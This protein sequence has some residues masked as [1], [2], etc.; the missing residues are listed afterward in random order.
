MDQPLSPAVPAAFPVPHLDD[1]PLL[2]PTRSPLQSPRSAVGVPRRMCRS[3]GSL[4][5]GLGGG[6]G[7]AVGAR[8]ALV[9]LVP[10]V[11][12]VRA[13]WPRNVPA[14]ESCVPASMPV[15]AVVLHDL[16]VAG[17]E[18]LGLCGMDCSAF[19][20]GV[21]A[22]RPLLGLAARRKGAAGAGGGQGQGYG[23]GARVGPVGG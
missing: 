5:L 1:A 23:S 12:R 22:L 16:G 9:P 17:H 8:L 7:G 13:V 18:L 19:V 15:S 2:L 20:E 21:A 6:S 10:L 4:G 3:A 11:P 14:P